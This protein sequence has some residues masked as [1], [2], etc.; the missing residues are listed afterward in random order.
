MHAQPNFDASPMEPQRLCTRRG[1]GWWK[2]WGRSKHVADASKGANASAVTQ[3]H[4][5]KRYASEPISEDDAFLHR[6]RRAGL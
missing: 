2:P 4:D 6:I 5:T 1:A 3:A